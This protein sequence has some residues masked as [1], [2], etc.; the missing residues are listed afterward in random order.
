MIYSHQRE[1]L[2]KMD[3]IND[4]YWYSYGNWLSNEKT[5]TDVCILKPIT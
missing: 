4:F 2:L 3:Y 5:I 1:H